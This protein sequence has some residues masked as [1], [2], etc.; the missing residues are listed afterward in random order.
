M[1][2]TAQTRLTADATAAAA[3]IAAA[4]A[5]D[6]DDAKDTA[7]ATAKRPPLSVQQNVHC[8]QLLFCQ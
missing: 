8:C 5:A 4:A 3:T 6:D 2:M 7:A 1:R